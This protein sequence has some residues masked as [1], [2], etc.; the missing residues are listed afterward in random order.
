MLL[1]DYIL[2]DTSGRKTD[3]GRIFE[4]SSI[5]NIDCYS[6]IKNRLLNEMFRS[7]KNSIA[8]NAVSYIELFI[9]YFICT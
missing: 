6:D 9:N 5:V 3:K 1:Y 8:G 2:R 7:N 4:R